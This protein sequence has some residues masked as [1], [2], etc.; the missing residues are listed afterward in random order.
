MESA[1]EVASE[2][3]ALWNG[4]GGQGWVQLQGVMDGLLRP[5]EDVLVTEA[6]AVVGARDPGSGPARVLDVGCGAGATTLAIARRLG[7][8]T[9]C[10]GLDISEPLVAAARGRAEADKVPARFVLADAQRHRFEPPALDLLVS[11]FGVM[12]FDDPVAA[13]TNLRSATA[14]TAALRVIIWRTAAE[15]PFMTEAARA[16]APFLALPPPAPDAPGQFAFG[17]RA[18]V[19]GILAD[20]GWTGVDLEPLDVTCTMAE[21]DLLAYLTHLGPLGRAL[22]ELDAATATEVIDVVR[23]A[24]DPYVHGDQVR[25]EAACWL[26]RADS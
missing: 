25:F 23:A 15:N 5:F 6:E 22:T 20:S 3:A 21:G 1:D 10:T 18:R 12:F 7:P 9:H 4:P 16:A 24:F 14:E 8:G 11:R 26:V 19:A 13:F 2:Q 17:D